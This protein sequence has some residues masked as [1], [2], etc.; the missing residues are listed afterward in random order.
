MT[1]LHAITVTCPACDQ[2]ITVP[3]VLTP[4]LLVRSPV[5]GELIA[6]VTVRTD[7]AGVRDHTCPD[8]GPWP[9]IPRHRR[10]E[11]VRAA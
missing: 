3:V 11:E 5:T 9:P 8:D 6:P 7:M 1:A 2:P 4:G 10:Y